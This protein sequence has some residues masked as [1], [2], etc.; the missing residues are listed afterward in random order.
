[1]NNQRGNKKIR[2]KALLIISGKAFKGYL[3]KTNIIRDDMLLRWMNSVIMSIILLLL[4]RGS[5]FQITYSLWWRWRNAQNNNRNI[6]EVV[7]IPH[8][9]KNIY[10]GYPVHL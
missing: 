4:M 7:G 6:Q 8:D 3:I 2:Q 9:D 10:P 5:E 1:M